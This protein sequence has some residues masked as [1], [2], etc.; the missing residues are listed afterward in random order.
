M[1][2]PGRFFRQGFGW[3][4]GAIV[5]LSAICGTVANAVGPRR[6][7]W[8]YPWSHD[9]ELR[10]AKHGVTL[11]SLQDVSGYLKAGTHLILDARP[12][13][14]FKAGHLPEA[15]SV[16][17]TDGVKALGEI[18][19]L[20]TPTQP[21]AVYCNNR[22]CDEGLLLCVLL[23]QQGFKGAVLMLEGFQRWS[24]EGLAVERGL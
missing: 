6:I 12:K 21:I 13:A 18:Q 4:V 8:T 24:A 5:L 9:L 1:T 2:T 14:E 19:A 20:L 3:R 11:V 23:H 10:A 15:F 16:P 17:Q 7:P 22:D